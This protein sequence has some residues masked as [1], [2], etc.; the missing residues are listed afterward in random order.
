MYTEQQIKVIRKQW[1][2]SFI[3]YSFFNYLFS[4]IMN[5]R[6]MIGIIPC[7]ELSL[8]DINM[9]DWSFE[10]IIITKLLLFALI[11]WLT[12]FFTYKTKGIKL[13]SCMWF[14]GGLIL[15]Y[16]CYLIMS[17]FF[18]VTTHSGIYSCK[19]A[20]DTGFISINSMIDAVYIYFSYQLFCV[21]KFLLYKDDK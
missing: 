9:H 21:N 14:L 12:Y 19:F 11:T 18:E 10:K 20:F 1:L 7:F 4:A 16:R 8:I 3:A 6:L 15:L 13:L 17:G 2:L 5:P